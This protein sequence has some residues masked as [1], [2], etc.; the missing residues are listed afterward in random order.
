M[1]VVVAI[2]GT[3]NGIFLRFVFAPDD[4]DD[5]DDDDDVV[6]PVIVVV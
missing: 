2:R 3:M 6:V 5:D 1:V 4:D